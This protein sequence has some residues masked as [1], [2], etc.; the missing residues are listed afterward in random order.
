MGPGFL[1][2]GPA[3][4]QLGPGFLAVV[5][6]LVIDTPCDAPRKHRTVRLLSVLP[7]LL[8]GFSEQSG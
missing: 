3:F 2:V 1:A 5:P 6:A 4:V 8:Q 7:V